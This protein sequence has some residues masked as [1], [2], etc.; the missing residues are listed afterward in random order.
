MTTTQKV[1]PWL[2]INNRL[3][4]S[5]LH[6]S[7]RA[8]QGDYLADAVDVDVD[9]A[10][11]LRRRQTYTPLHALPGAHSIIMTSADAGYLVVGSVLYSVAPSTAVMELV[12]VLTSNAP[13]S[14]VLDGGN[15]YYSN[16]TDSGRVVGTTR[17]PLGMPTPDSPAISAIGGGLLDGWY[18]V[19][20]S[21]VNA[22][23]GEEG[24]VSA[25]SNMELTSGGIRVT[26]PA[27]TAGATHINVY[28]SDANGELP[29]LAATVAVGTALVDLIAL[30]TGRETPGRFES[31]L[32][33]GRL[34]MAN[35]R[36]CSHAGSTVYVGLPY[37]HGY[38]LPAEGYIPFGA[39]VSNAVSCQFGTYVVADKTYWIPGDLGEVKDTIVTVLPYGG[40]PGTTFEFPDKSKVGWFGAKGVVFGSP[41]GE[42]EA[43]MADN[44]DLTPPASGFSAVLTSGGYRRVVSCG[45]CVNLESKA[46]TRYDWTLNSASGSFAIDSDGIC[47]TG[48]MGAVG[49]RVD[50]GQ[51]NFGT[52]ELKY[53]PAAYLAGEC[54]ERWMLT[55][56]LPSGVEY[57]YPSRFY[58]AALAVQR[59]DVGKGL[60]SS[61][62]A[63]EL[64]NETGADFT[65]A[66]V[67]F[68]PANA[69]RRI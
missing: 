26:L 52:D 64:T 46:A 25:S 63:L 47:Q 18:Q 54:D 22:T 40:V 45:W 20:V 35:G 14:Y 29:R 11:R 31:L 30:A 65:L 41:N 3:P 69:Q 1:G 66:K 48:I 39:D 6:I 8:L 5:A 42:V 37:R 7:T 36:L 58:D 10:G 28:L 19:G 33:A 16:G 51:I 34:F 4:A 67:S 17:Y 50:F 27:A 49:W 56:G 12:A 59:V 53:M 57:E 32:P 21:Y 2:G 38:Y 68:A 44:I 55:V 9:N 23:T 13:M 43:V 60:R 15:L 61:W 62:F 24:G